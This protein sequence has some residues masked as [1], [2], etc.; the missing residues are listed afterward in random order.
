LLRSATLIGARALGLDAD[1]GSLAPGKLD[2]MIAVELPEPVGDVEEY[3]VNGITPS[4]IDV[5]A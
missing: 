3:L 2:T 5:L 1:L 4:Q